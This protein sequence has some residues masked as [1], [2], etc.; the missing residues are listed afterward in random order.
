MVGLVGSP[1]VSVSIYYQGE[2]IANGSALTIANNF[3]AGSSAAAYI[4]PLLPCLS[5]SL[6][7]N[8]S[9]SSA[10]VGVVLAGSPISQC[11]SHSGSK[12]FACQLGIYVK[13]SD[14]NDQTN[15]QVTLSQLM[16][17]DNYLHLQL[18]FSKTSFANLHLVRDS[19][20]SNFYRTDC[21]PCYALAT[22][23]LY[24]CARSYLIDIDYTENATLNIS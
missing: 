24:H 15:D 13:A 21:P 11:S 6:I 14:T 4:L 3:A 10:M 23:L 17:S 20:F 8:N 16:M 1:A 7:S 5:T 22:G 9:A 12:V 18:S 19:F 2:A